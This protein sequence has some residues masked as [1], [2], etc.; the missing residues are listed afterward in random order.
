GDVGAGGAQLASGADLAQRAAALLALLAGAVAGAL[1]LEAALWLPL[2]LATALTLA[3][4]AL[5]RPA[6]APA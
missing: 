1:L 6:P 2:A 5:D 4:H 3:T